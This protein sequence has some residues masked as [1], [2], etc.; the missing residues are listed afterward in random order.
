MA[1]QASRRLVAEWL[2]S[3]LGQAAVRPG[4]FRF[5]I[6]GFQRK[7]AE[8]GSEWR[9]LKIRVAGLPE[10]KRILGGEIF[11]GDGLILGKMAVVIVHF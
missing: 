11:K 8:G 2:G 9:G 6:S 10:H 4:N 1:R 5:E 7:K 3:G